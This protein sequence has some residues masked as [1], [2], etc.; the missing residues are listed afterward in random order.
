MTFFYLPM[1]TLAHF[2]DSESSPT[3]IVRLTTLPRGHK[4]ELWA[5]WSNATLDC[6]GIVLLRVHI[7][8]AHG[9]I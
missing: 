9:V 2:Q 5:T 7:N 3:Y 4:G 6:G 8:L 1:Q